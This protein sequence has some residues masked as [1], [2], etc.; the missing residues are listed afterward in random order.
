M[1]N[2][3]SAI[4][5]VKRVKKQTLVN[6]LRKNKYK[7]AVKKIQKLLDKKDIKELDKYFPKFYEAYLCNIDGKIRICMEFEYIVG[8]TFNNFFE[9]YENI[10]SKTV[11]I[12][13]N[14]I[15]KNN[16]YFNDNGIARWDNNGNNIII[17][18][19]LSIKYIDLGMTKI[20][21]N[22]ENKQLDKKDYFILLT[23]FAIYII[24]TNIEYNDIL[25]KLFEEFVRMLNRI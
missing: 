7:A 21:D 13:L 25:S 10:N 24:Q 12:I 4:N 5:R 19:D 16:K 9:Y 23:K 17:K 15:I 2:T 18:E 22:K 8:Y 6:K 1:P 20:L 11:N 3:K 14:N